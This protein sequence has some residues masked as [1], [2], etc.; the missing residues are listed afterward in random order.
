MDKA[1]VDRGATGGLCADDMLVEHS[2][3][4]VDVSG[5]AGH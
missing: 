1:F 5:L 2:E 4:I 3:Q